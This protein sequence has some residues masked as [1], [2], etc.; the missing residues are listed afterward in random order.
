MAG[1]GFGLNLG[2]TSGKGGAGRGWLLRGDRWNDSGRWMDTA[3]WP[4]A[5]VYSSYGASDATYNNLSLENHSAGTAH[6]IERSGNGQGNIF[7]FELRSGERASF[8]NGTVERSEWMVENP[9]LSYGVEYWSSWQLYIAAGPQQVPTKFSVHGQVHADDSVVGASPILEWEWNGN[10]RLRLRTRSGGSGS[11]VTAD[12][13]IDNN[14]VRGRWYQIVT[15]VV[16]GAAGDAELQVWINGVLVVSLTG[17]SIGYTDDV[18]IDGPYL[19]FG[20]YRANDITTQVVSYG[21]MEFG[22][23]S[24]LS[25]VTNPLPLIY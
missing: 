3:F 20:D 13:Y 6:S 14:F 19:K 21:A 10:R 22:T 11:R 23:T 17:V 12:R 16:F 18:F 4:D 1:M 15:R 5:P 9:L 8:D 2:L 25:R 24:L 7:R